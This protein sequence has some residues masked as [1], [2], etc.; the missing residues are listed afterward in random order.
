VIRG[1]IVHMVGEQPF[2]VDLREMPSPNDAAL[3]CVNVR[4]AS[5]KRPTWLDYADSWIL[6]PLTQVRFLEVPAA[7]LGSAGASEDVLALPA[8]GVEDQDL[9]LDEDFLRRIRDA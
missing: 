6:I 2:L 5:G 8:G 3:L 4:L 1:A 7:A 9:E